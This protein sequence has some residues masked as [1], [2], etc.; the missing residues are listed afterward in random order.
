VIL[1]GNAK[2]RFPSKGNLIAFHMKNVGLTPSC[3]VLIDGSVRERLPDADLDFM[4]Y[5]SNIEPDKWKLL[6]GPF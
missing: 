4:R 3:I 2:F 6:D 1:T 5:S